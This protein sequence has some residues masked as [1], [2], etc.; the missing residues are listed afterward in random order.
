V[1]KLEKIAK[2][3]NN[4]IHSNALVKEYLALKKEIENDNKL[5]KIYE[6]LDLLRKKICKDKSENSD[7]YYK[8]LET[9][10]ENPKIARLEYLSSEIKG[11][12][13]EISD[14]LSLN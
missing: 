1:K 11:M 7:E 2:E 6:T 14:I 3:I 9:Y 10:K 5:I 8:L 13:V 12:M 4:S